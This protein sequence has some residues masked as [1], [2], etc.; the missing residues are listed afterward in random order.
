MRILLTGA[1][2]LVG[3]KLKESISCSKDM[4]LI[5]T[6]RSLEVNPL[7]YNYTFELL[8]I[9]KPEQISG[10]FSKYNPNVLINAAAEANVNFCEKNKIPCWKTNV[11]AVMNLVKYCNLYHTHLVHISTDFV[12]DGRKISYEEDDTPSP[13]NY[14]GITK[15]EGEQYIINECRK[16]SVIRTILLYGYFHGMKKDNIVTWVINSLSDNKSIK[17]VNDQY[18]CPTLAED[19]A[20]TLKSITIEQKEGIFHI[21]GNEMYTISEMAYITA[22][23]FG[24]DKTLISE[25]STLALNEPAPRPS[26]TRFN[27]MKASKELEFIPK[28]FQEGLKIIDKQI[29][30][31]K[32]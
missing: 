17:A 10:I 9:T 6:S 13:L 22:E 3:Q 20:N 4:E 16:W 27:L 21:S 2:G 29:N 24:L 26:R 19:L 31:K 15:Q 18:R 32:Y 5:A 8:D 11:E 30:K 23:Y 14:Y 12:F 25:I 7:E 1:N 28:T